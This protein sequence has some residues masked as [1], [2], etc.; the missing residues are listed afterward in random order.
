MVTI[1][2]WRL[3]KFK[4]KYPSK[5][6]LLTF[7]RFFESVFKKIT[8]EL[9]LKSRKFRKKEI[10]IPI[11]VSPWKGTRMG[12]RLL[13]K[14]SQTRI[15]KKKRHRK[16]K[17]LYNLLDEM[18]DTENQMSLTSKNVV[19]F[20][21]NVL[22]HAENFRSTRLF[23]VKKTR[24]MVYPSNLLDNLED[25]KN[26]FSGK[27]KLSKAEFFKKKKEA[28]IEYVRNTISVL[29]KISNG[30]SYIRK[31][32]ILY[33]IDPQKLARA[34]LNFKNA[35]K[36]NKKLRKTLRSN[37]KFNFNNKLKSNNKFNKI[38]SKKKRDLFKSFAIEATRKRTADF[39]AFKRKHRSKNKKI[40]LA[41]LRKMYSAKDKRI[42][43]FSF[44]GL[45]VNI[46]RE[47]KKLILKGYRKREGK[48]SIFRKFRAFYKN[49]KK[50]VHVKGF[51]IRK[52]NILPLKSNV[53]KIKLN[54]KIERVFIN[55]I[56]KKQKIK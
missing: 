39:N 19:E 43:F 17:F 47:R 55:N 30:Q 22:E 36:K 54:K 10:L 38:N 34:R 11:P 8:L 45:L 31:E 21:E 9:E 52:E 50:F 26:N 46:L 48:K 1:Y 16:H 29:K 49:T 15:D 2:N 13:L 41:T 18:W 53:K 27:K 3:K 24:R 6:E 7:S 20:T 4:T 32:G 25:A 14:N 40:P 33:K 35:L 5:K 42:Y 28:K 23:P 51:I 12:L 44:K 56:K 37:N